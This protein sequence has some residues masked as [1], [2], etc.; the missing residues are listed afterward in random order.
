MSGPLVSVTLPHR[1]SRDE[2]LRRVKAGLDR[3]R[4]QYPAQ[5]KVGEEKW[6]GARLT[7]RVAVLGQTVTG[8]IE[9]RD[10]EVKVEAQLTWLFAH[11]AGPAETMIKEQGA[12]M[13]SES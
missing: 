13:L 7:Y 3:V 12:A 5:L 9:V 8:T 1:L 11:Q 4:A 10:S 6:E 2:A